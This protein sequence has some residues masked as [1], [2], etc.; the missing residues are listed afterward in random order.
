MCECDC[1]S[2]LG[3]LHQRE[4]GK[5][6]ICHTEHKGRSCRYTDIPR[7]DDGVFDGTAKAEPS[8]GPQRTKVISQEEP[9]RES[10]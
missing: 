5:K 6:E 4:L 2:R 9:Q 10:G 1:P 7:E 8:Q 3:A